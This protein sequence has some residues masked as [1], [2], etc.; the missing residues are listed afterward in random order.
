MEI[1]VN[2]EKACKITKAFVEK[3]ESVD[4]NMETI[5]HAALTLFMTSLSVITNPDP[6]T[7]KKT[8]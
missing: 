1:Q 7:G 6:A 2:N 4:A 3:A 5:I 8:E